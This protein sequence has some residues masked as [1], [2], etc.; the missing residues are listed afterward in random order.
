M[1]HIFSNLAAV[2]DHG[3]DA[4]IDA[5]S[6]AEFAIDHIPGAVNLPV[7]DDAQRAEVGTIYKQVNPFQARKLGAA[8]VAQNAAA[9]LRGPLSDMQGGWRPLV[10]CW[11]GGQRSGSFATILSQVGWRAEL[12]DGGYRSYRRLVSAALHDAPLKHRLIVLEGHTGTAKT[13]ILHRLQAA[14]CQMIDL[15]GLAN[16]KG[17]VFGGTA[18]LQPSQKAFEG[19]LAHQLNALDP[20]NLVWVE[21]ESSKIGRCLVPPSFWA[22]MSRAP[23]VT[24]SAPIEARAD[25]LVQ[26]YGDMTQ[27]LEKLQ[28]VLARLTSLQGHEKV[29]AWQALAADGGHKQLALELVRDHYDPRYQKVGEQ[30]RA[31]AACQIELSDL[32]TASLDVAVEK[33]RALMKQ[34]S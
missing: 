24:V 23:R 13:E 6:P 11:R 1:A 31:D 3:F 18:A 16:H 19:A 29:V 33:L 28:S 5:R 17:S 9:H 27:E 7:L 34:F 10:Y 15:E 32:K 4:L 30:R 22:A 8:Y 25:Y 26:T 12:V 20:A 14:G 21:A 2:Y